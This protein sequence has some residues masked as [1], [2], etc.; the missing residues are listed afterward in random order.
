MGGSA[1]LAPSNNTYLSGLND[2][3]KDCYGGR[4]IR[5]GVREH[6]MG[7]IMS[8][9]YLHGGIRP[10][11]GTFLVFAD[12]VRPAVRVASL[13]KLPLI[14]IFTHDSVAV[15]EDGPTHQPVEHVASLR[16]IPGLNVIRPADANETADAWRVA[17]TTVDAPTALILRRP[18]S[19]AVSKD[20]PGGSCGNWSILRDAAL[21]CSSG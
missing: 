7:A 14:Y 19:A 21:G 18:P 16:A 1:D 20:A 11:G 6:A 8:G 2:F 15:G 5:F 3:Q 10:Y 9:M 12:Y 4:N 17:L 13:M